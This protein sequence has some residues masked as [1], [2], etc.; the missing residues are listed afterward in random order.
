L[1]TETTAAPELAHVLFMDIVGCSKLPT[2]EQ[3]RIIGRLQELVRESSEY[4]KSQEKDHL[5]SLPTGDGMALVF[6]NKLDAAVLCAVQITQGIQAESLCQIRMGVHT[7]PV[8]VIEDINHKRNVSG[9]GINLAERVMSC[10]TVGHILLSEQSAESL[11]HLSAWRDKIQSIGECQ[12]KDGWIRVW[13]LVDGPIGNPA[14]P[15]KSRRYAVRRKRAIG[16]GIS[17]LALAVTG[18]LGG[19]FW[20]GKG[21]KSTLPGQEQS[22]AVLPFRDMSPEKNQ[23]YLSE[24]LAEELLNGLAKIPGWRV[25]CRTSSFRFKATTEEPSA[26]GQKLNVANLVEGSVQKQGNRARISVQL[27]HAADGIQVSSNT[28][29][30]TMDD[31][32]AVQAEIARSVARALGAPDA[33]PALVGAPKVNGEAY[34]AFLQGQY[35]L[36]R[37]NQENFEKAAG[38]FERT[39][40]LAPAYAPG[41][42]G[43]GGLRLCQADWG[44]LHAEDGYRQA[45]EAVE[46]ALALDGNS[47]EAHS[48]LG[49]IK[50]L[51]DWDWSG[52][53]ESLQRA[54]KL[55]PANG[56]VL[57][58]SAV[59]ARIE[60][61]F[62][63][64]IAFHMRDL[65]LDPLNPT[66]YHDY[67][68]TLHYAAQQE[69]A[70]AALRK[71]LELSPELGNTHALLSRIALAQSKPEEALSEIQKES[72]EGFR[73]S[74]LPLAYHALGRHKESDS[75]LAE[76][77]AK[78][79]KDAP[80]QIA[81]TY[82]FR[83]E[84]DP[85]FEW[86]D[87]AYA[88]HDAGITEMKTDPLL[89]NLRGDVRYTALLAKMHLHGKL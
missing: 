57:L 39:I 3:K 63:D 80:Y 59:L 69:K 62:T 50:M 85:A 65:E 86:L 23:E 43:L 1:E 54:L 9:A 24:G 61:R 37:G 10:G 74:G 27:I 15:R 21:A 38:F 25:A 84:K 41:W 53:D 18:A 89:A 19:A 29:D 28:F 5:I 13:D 20:L 22:I 4:R 46:H 6:F 8:F 14:I 64:A 17:T 2:D 81:A 58:G 31:M 67:G 48:A 68:L 52:A 76:L 70:K 79:S 7:G 55:E 32:F 77:V 82:A 42:V 51:H 40:K 87:R 34:N 30:R 33:A 83:G 44:F 12:V 11:R 47:G 36:Q 56:D 66:A 26:I 73:A 71:S 35:F 45:R 72:H 49:Q 75:S 16:A 88:G 78:Y 60:G